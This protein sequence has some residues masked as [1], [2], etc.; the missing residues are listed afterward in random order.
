[1]G[2]LDVGPVLYGLCLGAVFAAALSGRD[3]SGGAALRFPVRFW[4]RPPVA[5]G[6]GV[7]GG[8]EPG[9]CPGLAG[10]GG[11]SLSGDLRHVRRRHHAGDRI[12]QPVDFPGAV[13]PQLDLSDAGLVFSDGHVMA[14]VFPG[15]RALH[16]GILLAAAQPPLCGPVCR[17]SGGLLFLVRHGLGAGERQPGRGGTATDVQLCGGTGGLWGGVGEAEEE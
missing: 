10:S 15:K 8:S 13:H 5:V 14:A 16:R 2:A 9:L 7:S 6:P 4:S 1:M 12:R 17:I 11:G 3:L